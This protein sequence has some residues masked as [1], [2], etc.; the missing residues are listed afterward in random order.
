MLQL[1][2]HCSRQQLKVIKVTTLLPR[3]HNKIPKK[4]RERSK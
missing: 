1:P 3:K 2:P 4:V